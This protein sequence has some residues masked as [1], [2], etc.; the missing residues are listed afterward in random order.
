MITHV[1]D[2]ATES[3]DASGIPRGAGGLAKAADTSRSYLYHLANDKSSYGRYASP[4][5][6][7]RLEV[8]AVGINALN[9]RLPRLLRTDLAKACRDCEFARKCLGES[10]VT[11]SEFRIETEE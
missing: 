7:R 11:E 10:V 3:V 2:V 8:A 1:D 9:P 6:A 5:L 4:E